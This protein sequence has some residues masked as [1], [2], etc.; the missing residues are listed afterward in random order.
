MPAAVMA[1]EKPLGLG[2]KDDNWLLAFKPVG[3]KPF[4]AL[5]R[6]AS[7]ILGGVPNQQAYLP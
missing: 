7:A 1:Q 6:E 3:F 4:E 5:N 2:F